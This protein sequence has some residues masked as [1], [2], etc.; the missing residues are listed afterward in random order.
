MS[1][2]IR[3]ALSAEEWAAEIGPGNVASL[4]TR[5]QWAASEV[6][7]CDAL[8]VPALAALALLPPREP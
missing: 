5:L 6:G 2:E 7:R 4:L 8:S 1:E 3:P